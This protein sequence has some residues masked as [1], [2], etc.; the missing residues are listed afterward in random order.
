[1]VR[2]GELMINSLKKYQAL[3]WLLLLCVAA[4]LA[5][6]WKDQSFFW[7]SWMHNFMG[8]F[9]VQFSLFK[10]INLSG[11]ADGF[12]KYDLLARKSRAYAYIYPFLEL[13]LGLLYLSESFLVPTYIATIAIMLFGLV[14]IIQSLA[15]GYQFNCACLGT[16]L[17]VKLSQISII[18]NLGMA[19]MA[20]WMFVQQL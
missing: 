15:R 1:M 6:E 2:G 7:S 5:I 8:F 9:F 10:L 4:S 14:G 19:L 3:L 12:S 13:A 11:F 18:E 16:V 20:A 17:Q